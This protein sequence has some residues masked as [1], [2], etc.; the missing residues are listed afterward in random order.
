VPSIHRIGGDAD[1]LL[2]GVAV[3]VIFDGDGADAVLLA[4]DMF[5]RREVFPRQTAM[6]HDHDTDQAP[7]TFDASGCASAPLRSSSR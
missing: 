6:C 3:V 7:A 2:L 4:H 1:F 5:H